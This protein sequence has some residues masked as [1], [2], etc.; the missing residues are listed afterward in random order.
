MSLLDRL[1]PAGFLSQVSSTF[2]PK[3]YGLITSSDFTPSHTD[4]SKWEQYKRLHDAG[5]I[6]TQAGY[7]LFT[8]GSSVPWSALPS[9]DDLSGE[10]YSDYWLRPDQ[11]TELDPINVFD[12]DSLVAG[13]QRAGLADA[14]KGMFTPFQASDL[15]KLDPSEYT[16]QLEESRSNLAAGL[17]KGL[18]TAS[19][20]G[21]GFA[22]YGG[23]QSAA[24]L[25]E[26]Q[27]EKGAS[28][29]Y[30]GIDQARA[31]AAQNLYSKLEGY[32]KLISQAT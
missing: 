1:L 26:Q 24:D 27:Y 3:K 9:G 4:R 30:A 7:D 14:D 10:G 28:D 18:E 25:A 2:G 5:W 29:L 20:I 23:R 13:F 6:P 32:D 19:G 21:G 12:P 16:G 8:G 15:R 22:G 17:Q 11:I 31:K